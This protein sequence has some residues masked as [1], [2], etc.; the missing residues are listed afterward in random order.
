[1]SLRSPA[2]LWLEQATVPLDAKQQLVEQVLKKRGLSALLHLGQGLHDIEYDS[3]KPV[4][5][6][7]GQP[8]RVL[9]AWL[10]LER[11]LHSK[12]RIEQTVL[13]QLS[14]Q[15]RHVSIKAGS[16]PSAAEDLVVLGVLIA[17][18][19][20]AGCQ[21][22][23]ARLKSGLQLW[24]WQDS[25]AQQAA[26]QDA[27]ANAQTHAWLIGWSAVGALQPQLNSGAFS[28]VPKNQEAKLLSDQIQQL[29][30][31]TFGE[32]LFL[33]DAASRLGHSTRSLQRKLKSEGTRYVD[34][35]ASARAERAS[36]MLS[37][38]QPSLSEIGF[39][40]GYTDQAHFCRD[41]K[42]R[43]GMS[44]LRYR[45]HALAEFIASIGQKRRT[46]SP[47]TA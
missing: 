25:P 9:Q 18:L 34:V 32:A 26:L 28:T 41:F 43:V 1:M 36:H 22:I 37:H 19:E 44:P 4:L 17:L 10:R 8:L 11:Y 16:S 40:C 2:K 33:P 30:T 6:H 15:H 5:I 27:C 38:S 39:A 3:L 45:E 12:H 46:N 42:R 13:T 7:A 14:V 35:I 21:Q 29:T 31:Q 24:P 23:E 20:I 47:A